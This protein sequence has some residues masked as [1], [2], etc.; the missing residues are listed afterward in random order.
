MSISSQSQ[1]S[2]MKSI[3]ADLSTISRDIQSISTSLGSSTEQSLQIAQTKLEEMA[4]IVNDVSQNAI[5]YS[6]KVDN[7]TN[8]V[9]EI[10]K[11]EEEEKT[12]L[13]QGAIRF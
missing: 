4:K 2:K 13:L 11:K 5:T 9:N 10:I 7:A 6:E 12:S 3:A 8:Q 1:I